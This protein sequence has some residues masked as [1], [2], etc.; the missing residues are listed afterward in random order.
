VRFGS[1][2]DLWLPRDS[3]LLVEVGDHL[4]GGSSV[5]AYWPP[6]AKSRSSHPQNQIAEENLSTS[7]KRT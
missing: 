4:K 7:G 2:A 3:E 1:R 6:R 5:V